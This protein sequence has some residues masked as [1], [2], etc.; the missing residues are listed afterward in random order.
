MNH[1]SNSQTK[2]E[3]EVKEK[4]TSVR[5]PSVMG[6]TRG[7]Q[8]G[9]GIIILIMRIIATYCDETSCECLF[10]QGDKSD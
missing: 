2:V 7:L 8:R 1:E 10:F 9:G 3:S 4:Q 6:N 5:L